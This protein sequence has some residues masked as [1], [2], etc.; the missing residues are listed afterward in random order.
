MCYEYFCCHN[1]TNT[2]IF[3]QYTRMGVKMLLGIKKHF[4]VTCKKEV[5]VGHKSLCHL[6]KV[7]W[8][9]VETMLQELTMRIEESGTLVTGE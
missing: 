7:G 6:N 3:V 4:Y 5:H 2:N 9:N 8:Q 1:I